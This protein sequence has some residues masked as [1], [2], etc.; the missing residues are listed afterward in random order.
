M[1]KDQSRLLKDLAKQALRDSALED[2]KLDLGE[3]WLIALAKLI[4]Q[5][6]LARMQAFVNLV[7][8]YMKD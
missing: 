6:Y 7:F 4:A 8:K 3:R 1:P 5:D 2:P